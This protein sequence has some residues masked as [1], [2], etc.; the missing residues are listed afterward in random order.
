MPDGRPVSRH[1]VHGMHPPMQGRR[2]HQASRVR[3][4]QVSNHETKTGGGSGPGTTPHHTVV[5]F[6]AYGTECMHSCA[7]RVQ[8]CSDDSRGR[9]PACAPAQAKTDGGPSHETRCPNRQ[10]DRP[11]K[12]RRAV[13][14]H[15]TR[16]PSCDPPKNPLRPVPRNQV[17]KFRPR[18]CRHAP[19]SAPTRQGF[20]HPMTTIL[21]G[22]N[23]DAFRHDIATPCVG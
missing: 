8:A 7:L 12:K 5:T 15:K 21:D 19:T 10:P 6:L 22:Q 18:A 2:T 3:T 13:Q 17:S 9:M 1:P 23:F 14:S 16:C 20:G 4:N 11:P